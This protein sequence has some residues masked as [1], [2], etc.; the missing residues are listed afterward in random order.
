[1]KK[2]LVKNLLSFAL[3]ALILVPV[4]GITQVHALDVGTNEVHNSIDLGNK[5]PRETVGEIIN[6]AMLFLGIIA[7]GI[8]LMGGFK[9]MTAGGNDEKV[10]EAKKLMGSGV[11]GLVIVLAAWGI[12]TF[13]LERLV[14]A[15]GN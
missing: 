8:I 13:I 6:V 12:A 10:G 9:W 15:T 2:T 4:L 1:M 11:I 7:V 3:I 14:N 5:D